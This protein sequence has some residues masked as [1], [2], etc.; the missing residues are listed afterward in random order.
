M[1]VQRAPGPAPESSVSSAEDSINVARETVRTVSKSL[2]MDNNLIALVSQ[3]RK[4]EEEHNFWK[5]TMKPENFWLMI[6]AAT[7]LLAAGVAL[8][9]PFA[10]ERRQRKQRRRQA[11]SLLP[12]ILQEIT[13]AW[14]FAV[15]GQEL[16]SAKARN[17]AF[18]RG[19]RGTPYEGRLGDGERQQLIGFLKIRMPSFSAAR[20][21]LLDLDGGVAADIFAKTADGQMRVDALAERVANWPQEVGSHLLAEYADDMDRASQSF[22]IA[23]NLIRHVLGWP[24][25]VSPT[26]E[27]L[28]DDTKS[29]SA[30]D[31]YT[32][33]SES[34]EEP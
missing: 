4:A 26:Q 2:E 19:M 31:F 11:E 6:T 16:A 34:L 13:K 3:S 29:P 28:L 14:W 9:T 1:R 23:A 22:R 12:E 21:Y 15:G 32:E 27:D 7:T 30:A 5:D 25:V 17:I 33:Q 10:L 8:F 20:S 18:L 24:S